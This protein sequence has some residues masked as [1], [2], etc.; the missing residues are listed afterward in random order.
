MKVETLHVRLVEKDDRP[1]CD[2]L[3]ND[4]LAPDDIDAAAANGVGV[5]FAPG[6]S[7]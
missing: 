4:T 2:G 5:L 6:D 3:D 1:D 7:P